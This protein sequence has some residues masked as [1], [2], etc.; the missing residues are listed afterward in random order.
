MLRQARFPAWIPLLLA[1]APAV[2]QE[3]PDIDRLEELR[4]ERMREVLE[5]NEE[6]VR[7]LRSDMEEFRRLSRE[8][9]E[10]HRTSMEQLGEALESDDEARVGEAL[11]ALER[12]RAEAQGLRDRHE[13]R[14]AELL[15]PEQ[16]ARFLL[17]NHHFDRRLNEL[18]QRRRGGGPGGPGCPPVCSD[19]LARPGHRMPAPPRGERL[20]RLERRGEELSP[21]E[22]QREIDRLREQIKRLEGRLQEMERQQP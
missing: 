21:A 22:R 13:R 7:A 6:Q 2:A 8:S 16:R 18:I 4:F 20:Q 5:L 14:L 3:Q 9:R 10:A 11:A 1:A 12:R 15:Q 19:S 17:F